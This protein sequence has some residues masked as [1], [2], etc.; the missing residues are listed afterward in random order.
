[1]LPAEVTVLPPED[2]FENVMGKF[3]QT[4]GEGNM[5]I[6]AL[7]LVETKMGFTS[8]LVVRQGLAIISVALNELV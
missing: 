7:G 2:V 1:V 4:L 5:A 3:V 6:A 8:I